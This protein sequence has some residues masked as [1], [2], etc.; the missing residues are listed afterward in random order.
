[1]NVPMLLCAVVDGK[2]EDIS[3]MLQVPPTHPSYVKHAHYNQKAVYIPFKDEP[4]YEPEFNEEVV[5][6]N[7]V[8]FEGILVGRVGRCSCGQIM[9][10]LPRQNL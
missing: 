8:E 2:T 1:M 3:K 7:H 4:V 6:M 10:S 5:H 9:Y